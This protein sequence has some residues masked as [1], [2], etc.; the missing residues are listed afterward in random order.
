MPGRRWWPS[1]PSDSPYCQRKIHV[2]VAL[3]DQQA[4]FVIRDEGKGFDTSTLPDPCDLWAIQARATGRGVILMRLF[5]D[6]VVSD[7]TGREVTLVKQRRTARP[8]EHDSGPAPAADPA[9]LDTIERK[10]RGE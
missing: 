8:A 4:E 3:N 1:T 5:M 2:Q 7:R 10:L 6:E 9:V